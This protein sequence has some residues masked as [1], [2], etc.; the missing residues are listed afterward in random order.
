MGNIAVIDVLV[1]FT[2]S[3]QMKFSLDWRM[4]QS[5]VQGRTITELFEL[6]YFHYLQ[7]IRL[8]VQAVKTCLFQLNTTGAQMFSTC[9]AKFVTMLPSDQ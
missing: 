7:K 3:L 9:K 2:N 6:K 8:K 5:H 4:D 1:F